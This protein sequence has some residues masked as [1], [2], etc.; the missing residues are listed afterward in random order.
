MIL[1]ILVPSPE[2]HVLS[3]LLIGQCLGPGEH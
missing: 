3:R 2:L 1:L